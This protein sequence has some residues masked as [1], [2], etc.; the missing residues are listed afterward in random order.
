MNRY[1]M[2][3]HEN[4]VD[5]IGDNVNVLDPILNADTDLLQSRGNGESAKCDYPEPIPKSFHDLFRDNHDPF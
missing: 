1:D 2:V 3:D 4:V 5:P